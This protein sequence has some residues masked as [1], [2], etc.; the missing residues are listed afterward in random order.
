MLKK[1]A[2]D[3]RRHYYSG[4]TF[5]TWAGGQDRTTLLYRHPYILGGAE[6]GE[7]NCS[8]RVDKCHRRLTFS[9]TIWPIKPKLLENLSN[10]LL[11]VASWDVC[12][13]YAVPNS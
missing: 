1:F 7:P 10:A 2:V 3:Q 5:A 4:R 12:L 13:E 9:S 8:W 11:Y 6:I